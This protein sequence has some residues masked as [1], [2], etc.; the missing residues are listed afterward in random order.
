L[1]YLAHLL[2]SPP[3][4]DSLLGSVLGD[5]IKGPVNEDVRQRYGPDMTFAIVLH[6]RIDSFTDAHPVVR[7]SRNRISPDRRRFA[8]VMVDLFYDHF[9]AKNWGDYHDQPLADFTSTFYSIVA[10]R[11][12]RLPDHFRHVSE[13]MAAF[14][15]LGSY[16]DVSSI[17]SAL[18]RMSHRLKRENTLSGSAQELVANYADLEADFRTFI[19]DAIV[20]ARDASSEARTKE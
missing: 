13:L 1:N 7:E 20:F 17:D 12:N 2:L 3:G 8:G 9:L 19:P 18:N 4:E 16:A 11:R 14:D 10:Q 5:F 15:W 6:R